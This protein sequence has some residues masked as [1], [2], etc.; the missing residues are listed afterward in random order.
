VDDTQGTLR[1]MEKHRTEYR[2]SLNWMKKVSQELDPDTN[3]QM[4]KFRKVQN[5]VKTSKSHFDK[6]KLASLQKVDLLAAA[7]C[8]MFS[9]A[10]IQYLQS[11]SKTTSKNA[12]IFNTLAI[13]FKGYQYF[14]FN[15]IKELVEPSK[16]LAEECGNKPATEELLFD[17][18]DEVRQQ[19]EEKENGSGD[20][21]NT[22]KKKSDH[23]QDLLSLATASE[24]LDSLLG[25]IDQS[26]ETEKAQDALDLGLDLPRSSQSHDKDGS[27]SS[28]SLI[29][30]FGSKSL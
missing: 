16:K 7:R 11:M 12:K 28:S 9:H 10:L 27:S 13:T 25:P 15:I 4:E 17:F 2:A 23:N 26:P 29:G 24:F 19:Q 22:L 3:K 1:K 21:A 20:A 30:S 8:N 18:N 14:E 6:L 5:H